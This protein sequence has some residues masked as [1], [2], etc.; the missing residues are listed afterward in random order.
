MLC[1]TAK[2]LQASHLV[3][4]ALYRMARTS[5]RR[6][7]QDPVLVTA[8]GSKRSSHQ[9]T[10]Y[11][12]CRD[13]EQRLS[14]NGE[15][16]VMG[17]VTRQNGRFPLLET[18]QKKQPTVAG[19]DWQAYSTSD[20]PS[21]DRAMIAY[22]ASSV[23][24]RASIHTWQQQSGK[25]IRIDLGARYNEEVRRYLM[26]ESGIPKNAALQVIVCSDETNQRTFFPP[27]ENQRVK[28]RSVIFLARGILFFFRIS[29]TLAGF[30]RRLSIVNNAN[31]WIT[32]RNCRHRQIWSVAT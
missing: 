28:D 3:P 17:L 11:V 4:K 14:R 12:F 27:Y 23:V 30:Q 25:T 29:N 5:G 15:E 31:G 2:D 32:I 24:W 20:T 10:D 26:G 21:I 18:L 8:Q 7:N 22:F 13:C 6:G 16:Y 9:I 1:C 19:P